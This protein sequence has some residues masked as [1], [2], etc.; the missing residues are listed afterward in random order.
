MKYLTLD[1]FCK[2]PVLV[3]FLYA[4]AMMQQPVG[5]EMINEGIEKHPEYFPDEIEHRRKVAMK[6]S[7]I[8]AANFKRQN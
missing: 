1:E 6:E 4:K 8:V 2:A 7:V 5:M 3:Q